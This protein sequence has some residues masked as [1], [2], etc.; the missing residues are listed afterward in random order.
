MH[1]CGG[2]RPRRTEG[3]I[4]DSPFQPH[5]GIPALNSTLFDVNQSDVTGTVNMASPG[6]VADAICAILG[7]RYAGFDEVL[8]RDGFIDIE[9]IFWGRR[10]GFLPCDTPYHDLRH[11]MSTALAMTRMWANTDCAAGDTLTK[12]AV[13]S[14]TFTTNTTNSKQLLYVIEV[15]AEDLDVANGFDCVRI[16]SASMVNAVGAAIYLLDGARYGGTTPP[17]AITD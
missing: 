16:D 12:T 7:K 5:G 2:F 13:T 6:A 3:P 11:S 17:A 14:D 1:F 8:L 4:L 9:D 15:L 10:P